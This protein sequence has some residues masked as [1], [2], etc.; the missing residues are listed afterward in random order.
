LWVI[1][2]EQTTAICPARTIIKDN[3]KVQGL[4]AAQS[5]AWVSNYPPQ[6]DYFNDYLPTLDPQFQTSRKLLIIELGYNDLCL[7][8]FEW[9]KDLVFEQEK[10][11]NN[12]RA[13]L[14]TIRSQLK[15]VIVSIIPP[16]NLSQIHNVAA[17]SKY[18]AFIR[19]IFP[20]ECL[21]LASATNKLS[22]SWAKMDKLASQYAASLQKLSIEFNNLRDPSFAVSYDPGMRGLDIS[23]GRPEDVL[24]AS[25]CFHPSKFSHDMFGI[26]MW[27]NYWFKR[28]DKQV[29][30]LGDQS[31][32]CP[33]EESRFVIDYE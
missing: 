2:N 31:V 27:N 4:N 14:T 12:F 18:C 22:G 29:Y 17:K 7:G 6:L 8:C 30:G 13:M 19:A 9:S 15:N 26:K 10:F 20:V 25:D 5:G 3:I 16:F 21:C 33:T 32:L 24:S 23:A 1:E 11:E 28:G